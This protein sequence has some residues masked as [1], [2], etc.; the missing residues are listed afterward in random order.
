MIR[1]CYFKNYLYNI[2]N[3]SSESGYRLPHAP[4]KEAACM[5]TSGQGHLIMG[6]SDGKIYIYAPLEAQPVQDY[7][8][9]NQ[10]NKSVH[11]VVFSKRN[12][13]FMS[14]SLDGYVKIWDWEGSKETKPKKILSFDENKVQV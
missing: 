14:G 10:H 7:V 9:W 5:T 13:Y 3:Y 1:K 4:I 8:L 11:T 6:S 12:N 2:K